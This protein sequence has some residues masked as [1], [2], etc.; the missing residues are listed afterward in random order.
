MFCLITDNPNSQEYNMTFTEFRSSR[1][2]G[3]SLLGRFMYL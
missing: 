2:G 3:R 1:T